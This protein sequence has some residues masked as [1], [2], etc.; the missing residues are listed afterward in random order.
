LYGYDIDRFG[1]AALVVDTTSLS[2][3]EVAEEIV[4]H[5]AEL[6]GGGP[7]QSQQF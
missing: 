1:F 2:Q 5:A 4:A 6:P 3:E 7:P